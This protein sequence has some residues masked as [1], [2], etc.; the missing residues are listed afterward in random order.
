MASSGRLRPSATVLPEYLETPYD[1]AR[2]LR[3]HFVLSALSTYPIT[4]TPAHK[5]SPKTTLKAILSHILA[6]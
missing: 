6:A 5:K 2:Q 3:E 4:R 1:G